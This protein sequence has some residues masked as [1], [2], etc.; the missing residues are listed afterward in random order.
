MS[1]LTFSL[2]SKEQKT[3]EVWLA[4]HKSVCRAVLKAAA[5]GGLT[6]SF[7]P[8]TMGTVTHVSCA[9]GDKAN[10]TDFENW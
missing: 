3:F 10:I 6:F 9:C 1:T 2:S 4:Q 5:R 8:T 7:H